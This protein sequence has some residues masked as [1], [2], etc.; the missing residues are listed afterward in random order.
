[1]VKKLYL[2][3]L[4]FFL[5]FF[6]LPISVHAQ[7]PLGQGGCGANEF[8]TAIGCIPGDFYGVISFLIPWLLGIAGGIGILL[9]VYAGFLISTSAG[10]PKQI[11][12][13]KE[14]MAAAI[15]GLMLLILSVFI[16]RFLGQDI[17][18]IPGL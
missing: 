2:L 7:S 13:G 6:I 3:F 8:Y 15:S 9:I 18:Q 11:A 1:M 5:L 14:L 17:L 4:I 12:A 10:N 16:V